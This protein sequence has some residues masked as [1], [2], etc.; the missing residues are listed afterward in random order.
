M[1]Q[2]K[3]CSKEFKDY[4]SLG[5]HIIK[6]HHM[7]SK[8]YYDKFILLDGNGVCPVCGSATAFRTL[9]QGYKTYCSRKCAARA[10]ADDPARNEHKVS[11]CRETMLDRHDVDNPSK[12]D[13]AVLKRQETMMVTYGVP[14]YSQSIQY[15]EEIKSTMKTRYG[16]EAYSQLPEMREKIRNAAISRWSFIKNEDKTED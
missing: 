6:T 10:I 3:I 4:T 12:I 11:A 9:G 14:F 13:S 7:P 1:I 2:C 15:A 8:D 5:K 16:V